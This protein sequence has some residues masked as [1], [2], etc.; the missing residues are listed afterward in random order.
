MNR[1]MRELFN[2]YIEN[3]TCVLFDLNNTK[4]II[5]KGNEYQMPFLDIMKVRR[6]LIAY[7]E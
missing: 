1:N 5:E 4:K 7:Y 6:N 3:Y 2:F